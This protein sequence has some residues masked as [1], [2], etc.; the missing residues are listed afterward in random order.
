MGSTL[1]AADPAL[2]LELTRRLEPTRIQVSTDTAVLSREDKSVFSGNVEVQYGERRIIADEVRYDPDTGRLDASGNVRYADPRIELDGSR[3]EFETGDETGSFVSASF[4][5][6]AQDG[7]GEAGQVWTRD[8]NIVEL[9][10]VSYTTCPVDNDDWVLLAPQVR[11]DRERGVGVGRNVQMKFKGVPILYAPYLSFPVSEKRKSGLLVP[12][13]GRSDSSGTDFSL[14]YYWNMAPN[15]DAIVTPRLL[16]KRGV[17]L[18]TDFRYLWPRTRGDLQVRY[19]PDDKESKR[20]RSRIELEHATRFDHGWRFDARVQHVSD[21]QYFEDLGSSLGDA[22][23]TYLERRADVRYRGNNWRLLAR[24]QGF[25]TLAANIAEENR[26]YERVPQI[27]ANGNWKS[28]YGSNLSLRGELVNFQ[29]RSGVTGLRLDLRPGVSWPVAGPGYTFNPRIELRHTR[30]QLDDQAASADE[31]PSFTAP[32]FSVDTSA[33]FERPV[34]L[35]GRLTQTLEPRLQYTHIPFRDQS[36]IPVFDSGEPDFNFVQLFRANRFTGGDRL[37]DTDK[38]S[39]GLT[40][41]LINFADGSELLSATLGQAIFLSDRAVALPDGDAPVADESSLIGEIGM[42]FSQRWNADVGYQW[43][44]DRSRSS[45]AEVRV[46]FRPGNSSVLNLSYRFRREE[47]EQSDLSFAVPVADRW[48]LVGRWNYS[49]Q[50]DTTLERFAG[51]EYETCC[52]IARVVS[53]SFVNNIDGERDT[54]L[55]TQL[56]FKGLASVGGRAD[57]LLEDGILGYSAN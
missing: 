17:Q 22:S 8:D 14:P 31:Q 28:A 1:A 23:P 56:H 11:L 54:A 5:L 21:D 32:V 4:R 16:S 29:R 52:W 42:K 2:Q 26:P 48:N 13:I 12:D 49:L 38:L 15:Y 20:N 57:L 39:V 37:G 25:Q 44:P 3:G 6:P 34:G 7:R 19:L 47:L 43:D 10:D 53:R 36:G 9:R 46:Q 27:L 45:K 33:V 55:F 40:S 50:D 35:N 24:T 30:Y 18:R 51:G 41:R